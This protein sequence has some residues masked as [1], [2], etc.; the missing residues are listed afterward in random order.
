MEVPNVLGRN[1]PP[2]GF[3]LLVTAE[4][5]DIFYSQTPFSFEPQQHFPKRPGEEEPTAQVAKQ[6]HTNQLY[7]T[8]LVPNGPLNLAQCARDTFGFVAPE[9]LL[10]LQGLHLLAEVLTGHVVKINGSRPLAP[11]AGGPVFFDEE[12][13]PLDEQGLPAFPR[14]YMEHVNVPAE[15][16]R[17]M[18][19][20]Y[21]RMQPVR[22]RLDAALRQVQ[23]RTLGPSDERMVRIRADQERFNAAMFAYESEMYGKYEPD[24]LDALMEV[25]MKGFN[26]VHPSMNFGFRQPE[27]GRQGGIVFFEISPIPD[28]DA[29]TEGVRS[30]RDPQMRQYA[31]TVLGLTL[32]LE[33][34][35]LTK[36]CR[37]T[38]QGIIGRNSQW[39]VVPGAPGGRIPFPFGNIPQQFNF[40][41][42]TL[43]RKW[44][45]GIH[46]RLLANRD[47]YPQ[48]E[49]TAERLSPDTV[50]LAPDIPGSMQNEVQRL[51]QGGIRGQR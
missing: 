27:G 28:Y 8:V 37:W 49:I 14:F 24:F 18:V 38:D 5:A 33:E 31:G 25:G 9:G 29:V 40:D 50:H 32:A 42:G 36:I 51:R 45:A 2:P 43:V 6:F 1:S 20:A 15:D 39:G 10:R 13:P 11:N 48:L 17:L 30:I 23:G 4:E 35:A 19:E 3:S 34:Q 16:R 46:E 44:Q 47:L 7:S 12:H 21:G 41:D 26:V 22:M